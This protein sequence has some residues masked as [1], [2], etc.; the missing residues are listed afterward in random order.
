MQENPVERTGHNADVKLI[1]VEDGSVQ[2]SKDT[3][4]HIVFAEDKET[5]PCED[6][7]DD[8]EGYI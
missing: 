3:M 4:V 2:V 5:A 1:V 8:I 7:G 6:G